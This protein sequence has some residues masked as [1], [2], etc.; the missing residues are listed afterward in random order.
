[1]EGFF[2]GMDVG[3]DVECG[4]GEENV[5][6]ICGLLICVWVGGVVCVGVW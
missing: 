5:V 3:V 1:V 4:V 6:I 2:G